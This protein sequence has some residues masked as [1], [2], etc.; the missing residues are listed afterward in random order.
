MT[1]VKGMTRVEMLSTLRSERLKLS[2][3]RLE[4]QREIKQRQAEIDRIDSR[5]NDI[6]HAEGLL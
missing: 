5:L 1:R 4:L 2:Q 6:E 3:Q